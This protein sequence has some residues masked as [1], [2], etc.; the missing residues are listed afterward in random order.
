MDRERISRV[1]MN[2]NQVASAVSD[3][4]KGNIAT[5]FVDQGVEFEVLVELDPKDKSETLDLSNI[6][7]Q[8]PTYGWMPLKNL[9]R[10][11]RYTGPTNVMRINQERVTEITAELAGTDLKAASDQARILSGSSR[12]ARW[13]SI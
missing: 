4:V 5:S 7:I 12:L 3:A 6:Q 10:L 1:G 8:T 13:V 11:E 9:A 2:T